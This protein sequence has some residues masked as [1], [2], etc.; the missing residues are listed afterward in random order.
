MERIY[1]DK[2]SS[3]K[4][5]NPDWEETVAT[6]KGR[7]ESLPSVASGAVSAEDAMKWLQVA[8]KLYSALTVDR[9]LD[10]ASGLGAKDIRTL[11][12]G[13]RNEYFP[14]DSAQEVYERKHLKS[15]SPPNGPD[16][17][18]ERILT[19]IVRIA[20]QDRYGLERDKDMEG[21]MA[22]PI[23]GGKAEWLVGKPA[24]VAKH[25]NQ[26]LLFDIQFS[27]NPSEI[28]QADQIRLHYYDLVANNTGKAPDQLN[29]A[30]VHIDNHLADTLVTLAQL[31]KSAESTLINMVREFSNLPKDKFHIEVHQ[32]N[33]QPELYREIID[34]GQKH[35][36][37]ILK[38]EGPYQKVDP[39]LELSEEKKLSYT[40]HAKDFLVASQTV[41]AAEEQRKEAMMRFVE[42]MRG[43]DISD[44]FS[45]PY[46]GALLRKY[47]YFDA[48]AAASYLETNMNVDPAHLRTPSLNVDLLVKAFERMGGDSSQFYENGQADKKAIE[49][50]AGELG[51]DLSAFYSRQMKAIVNPKTRGPIHEAIADIRTTAS[52][53]VQELNMNLSRSE[54]T[55]SSALTGDVS[56]STLKQISLKV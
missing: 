46:S 14:K 8:S 50:A 53:A 34:S 12:A 39:P 38:G 33:K 48:E 41:K 7:L 49:T 10:Q 44:N 47:D 51:L 13:D 29:L 20:L 40:Q 52:A 55:S 43:F 1:I 4:P 17:E 18:R 31:S 3:I 21:Q 42:S 45:P 16:T 36:S 54:Q 15:I 25:G 19:S 32:V 22:K 26:S 35:W 5:V 37:N 9:L 11:V 27:D 28:S 23:P 2:I 6:H 30:S 56:S 24:L